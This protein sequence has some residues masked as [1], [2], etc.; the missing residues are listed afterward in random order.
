MNTSTIYSP[1]ERNP[2]PKI[3]TLLAAIAAAVMILAGIAAEAASRGLSLQFGAVEPAAVC[4][5][6]GD[7][8][9][10]L[11]LQAEMQAQCEK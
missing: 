4:R 7:A 5:A 1:T 6:A 9:L 3:V 11:R 2:W 8:L 10:P